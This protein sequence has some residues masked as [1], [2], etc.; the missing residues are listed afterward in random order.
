MRKLLF[1]VT[2]ALFMAG[3]TAVEA[4][5]QQ[6]EY[7]LKVG[8]TYGFE[9]LT[10]QEIHQVITGM[11]N[12]MKNTIGGEITF[13][14]KSKIDNGYLMDVKYESLKFKMESA[15]MNM[16]FDSKNRD[17]NNNEM[18][19]MAFDG[20]IGK[21]FEVKM[22]KTGKINSV[23][24]FEAALEAMAKQAG[25][26]A[27]MMAQVTE[28]LKQQFSDE[29]MK[30]SLEMLTAMF[31]AEKRKVGESWEIET[32]T[33]KPIGMNVRNT[34]TLTDAS[35]GNWVIKGKGEVQTDKEAKMKQGAMTQSFDLSGTMTTESVFD[36]ASGWVKEVKQEQTIEG[37]VAIESPQLPVTMEIPMSIK[38]V[39]T[40]RTL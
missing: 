22:D 7:N 28:S 16:A 14:V 15:V 26:N 30:Q 39:T 4:Q 36:A 20:I 34:Y 35:K 27:A 5:K 33:L 29:A 12:D 32:R 1:V 25:S 8:E 13:L 21:N 37:Q 11:A 31:P 38:S 18:L 40:I 23:T 6:L 2:M 19:N 24:G 17:A 9:Q 3:T 10:T